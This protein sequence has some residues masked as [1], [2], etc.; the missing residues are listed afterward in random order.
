M[1]M[2]RKRHIGNH[3]VGLNLL[4]HTTGDGATYVQIYEVGSLEIFVLSKHPIAYEGAIL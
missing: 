3:P 2:G 1:F 4:T